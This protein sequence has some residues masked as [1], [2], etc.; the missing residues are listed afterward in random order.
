MRVFI[1]V[2]NHQLGVIMEIIPN[3][4]HVLRR[5]LV[6]ITS[7]QVTTGGVQPWSSYPFY[8]IE[9]SPWRMTHVVEYILFY[10]IYCAII[11]L[12]DIVDFI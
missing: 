11:V 3:F 12:A 7:I 5:Y 8:L 10:N 1:V 6:F 2:T 9:Y 4:K